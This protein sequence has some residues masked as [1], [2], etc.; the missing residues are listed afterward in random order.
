MD[1]VAAKWLLVAAT[2]FLLIGSTIQA[3]IELA[4]YGSLAT[5]FGVQIAGTALGR[6]R[7]QYEGFVSD[8][9]ELVGATNW[10]QYARAAVSMLRR[11]ARYYLLSVVLVWPL[12]WPVR[13]LILVRKAKDAW[14]VAEGPDEAGRRETKLQEAAS[15]ALGW[16]IVVFGAGLALASAVVDVVV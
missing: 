8:F 4:R 14:L 10:N 7:E 12:W 5:S 2:S 16:S 6:A 13:A 15:R 11:L 3:T 9:R 1:S